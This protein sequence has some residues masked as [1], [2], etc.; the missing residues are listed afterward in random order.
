MASMGSGKTTQIPQLLLDNTIDHGKGA[1]CNIIYTQPQRIS[2]I[3]VA[4]RVANERG[5]SLSPRSSIGY[6]VHFDTKIPDLYGSVMFCTTGLFLK[7]MQNVLL[8]GMHNDRSLNDMT[9][10]VVDEVHEHDVDTDLLLVILKQLLD[11]C[12]AQ[13][14]PIKIILMW[15]EVLPEREWRAGARQ[16]GRER[17]ERP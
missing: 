16:S 4:Q 1:F 9:H 6:Q 2:A 8:G 15:T 11:V 3:S 10:I 14:R 7:C 5:K 12:K 17:R 13:N